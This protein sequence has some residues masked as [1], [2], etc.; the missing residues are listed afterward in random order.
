L[1]QL[2]LLGSKEDR[3]FKALK[4]SLALKVFKELPV[5]KAILV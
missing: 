3:E 1:V 4:E 2:V 5:L